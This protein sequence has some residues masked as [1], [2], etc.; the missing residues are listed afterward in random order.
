MATHST[1]LAWR[2][3]WTEEP[4]KLQS[5]GSKKLDTTSKPNNKNNWLK[6]MRQETDKK[7]Q[8]RNYPDQLQKSHSRLKETGGYSQTGKNSRIQIFKTSSNTAVCEEMA[9]RD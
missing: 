8:N 3:P 2:I 9:L 6:Q 5:I 4:G 7:K 1:I